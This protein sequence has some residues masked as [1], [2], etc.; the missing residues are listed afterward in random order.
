VFVA[1]GLP[2][3]SAGDN[4]TPP[5]TPHRLNDNT[6]QISSQK[7]S[8][9]MDEAST[10]HENIMALAAA[11]AMDQPKEDSSVASSRMTDIDG[12]SS[13]EASTITSDITFMDSAI[14]IAS[15]IRK[16]VGVTDVGSL[17][18]AAFRKNRPR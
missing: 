12:A 1:L 7:V 17:F 18:G 16:Q 4:K 8:A 14:G 11:V 3:K 2:D 9:P 10:T 15:S 13:V 5:T 6:E